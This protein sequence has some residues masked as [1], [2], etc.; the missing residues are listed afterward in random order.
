MLGRSGLSQQDEH[1]E[2]VHDVEGDE[3]GDGVPGY[4]D[5][6]E[7]VR[8]G[9]DGDAGPDAGTDDDPSDEE[10]EGG[11]GGDDGCSIAG[12]GRD[13]LRTPGLVL[14]AVLGFV[15]RRRRVI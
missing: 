13:G 3:D 6:N 5:D 10:D 8:P 12:V 11:G 15:L 14:L 9:G 2:Q 4:L 1:G 7:G